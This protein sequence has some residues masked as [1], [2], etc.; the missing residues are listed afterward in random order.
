[1]RWLTLPWDG[2]QLLSR[3]DLGLVPSGPG[4]YVFSEDAGPLRP[5]PPLSAESDPDYEAVVERLR[6]LPC[7]LYVGK[8]SGLST[9]LPGYRFRPYLEVERRSGPP[10]HVTSP[11][12]G[13]RCCTPSGS[14]TG[15]RTSA[16]RWTI[17]LR[18]PSGS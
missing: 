17:R 8:A 3:L 6:L 15:R 10:R 14:S 18:R 13:G 4:V 7:V 5:H 2:P 1:M 9:R 12:R 16:G 11:Q